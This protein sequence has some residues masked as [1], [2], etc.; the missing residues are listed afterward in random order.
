MT[1]FYPRSFL[2][3]ILIGNL[4]V[5]TPLLAAIAYVSVSI[6]ILASRSEAAMR[7]ASHAS[8]LSYE[9]PED[10]VHMDRVLRQY[11][12]LADGSLLD[13]YAVIRRDWRRSSDDLAAI[14]LLAA[15]AEQVVTIEAEEEAAFRAFQSGTTSVGELRATLDQL[16]ARLHGVLDGASRLADNELEALRLQSDT[17]RQRLL[18][19][20][21]FGIALALIFV[22]FGR[23][24]LTRL[25]RR[26]ERAV[27]ALGRGKLE[28]E[29]RLEG[30]EDLQEIGRRLDWLRRRMLALE[31]ERTLVLRHVSH[32]L[33]TPLAA[34]REG[35]SLLTEGAAG[36]L[37]P[38]QEKIVGIMRNNA[39][40]LQALIDGLLKLQQAGYAGNRLNPKP[41]RLDEL[42]QQV[43]ATHQLAAR[44]KRLR[45]SGTL[46]PLAVLGGRE[47]L[48]TIVDNLVSN[49]I[50]FSPQGG[51][52]SLSL[53][54]DGER[55]VLDVIDEG[56][57]VPAADRQKI[58]EP[59]YRSSNSKAVVGI[60]LGLAIAREFALA[61]RG[62]LELVDGRVGTHFRAVLPLGGP[63]A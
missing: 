2:R 5:A 7:Q 52:V 21:F 54:R 16:K 57:G 61:H 35:A 44:N 14:P 48:T 13:D 23:R 50:K 53:T 31:E 19:A 45:F 11:Q 17:L 12:V 24:V 9:L 32:E 60:G 36:S 1:R 10:F 46:A 18:I 26:F 41:V 56:P 51:N 49:A 39:L 63:V 55:A 59:F 29:I 33:K 3:L 22:A 43:L 34:L 20:E 40:R 8:R 6:D 30:P 38:G 37:T 4:V 25:L 62:T 15:V 47:E 42:T 28:Q 27:I 58:F